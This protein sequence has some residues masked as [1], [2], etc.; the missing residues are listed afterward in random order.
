MF[1]EEKLTESYPNRF[2]LRGETIADKRDEVLEKDFV[3]MFN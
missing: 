3:P 1:F 2:F